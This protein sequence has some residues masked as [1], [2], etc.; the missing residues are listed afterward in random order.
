MRSASVTQI[1]QYAVLLAVAVVALGLL[2]WQQ[3][4][5]F[6]GAEPAGLKAALGL[7]KLDSF[8]AAD[9]L[10]RLALLFSWSPGLHRCRIS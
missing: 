6:S 1:L 7:V 4:A 9:G 2:V 8:A 5:V 10:N 3:G